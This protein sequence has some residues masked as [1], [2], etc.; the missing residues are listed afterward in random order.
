[1]TRA[2]LTIDALE[3]WTLFG[4]QWHPLEL[5]SGRAVVELCS[6]TG[7]PVDVLQSNDPAV[8]SY[9]RAAQADPSRKGDG[10]DTRHANRT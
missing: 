9:L 7:E 8:I 1:M 6:C 3:R 4:A 10:D 5:S 2:S